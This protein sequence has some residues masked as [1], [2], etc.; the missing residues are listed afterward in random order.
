MLD[1]WVKGYTKSE[2]EAAQEKFGIVFPPDLINLYLEK[3]PVGGHD[4]RNEAAIRKM[5]SWPLE[6]LLF[7]VEHNQLWWSEWGKR[8]DTAEARREILALVVSRA[9]R[10][11][12]LFSHRFLPASPCVSGNPVFSVYGADVI[13]YGANLNDYFEREFGTRPN[14]QLSRLAKHIPFWSDLARNE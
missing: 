10:L 3:R 8:P 12:P 7:D 1:Q 11:I 2:L 5:L 14:V 13:A 4:W 6:T 9:P